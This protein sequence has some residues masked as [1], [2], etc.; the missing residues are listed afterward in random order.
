MTLRILVTNDD[1]INGHGLKVAEGIA[2]TLSDDVWVVAPESEQSGASHSLTLVAPLR[3]R[4]LDDRHFSLTGTPTDC[5][6]MAT[7]HLLK[8]KGPDL[9]ISGVNRGVNVADDVTYS[10]T[11]AGAMEG[12]TLGIPSVALSQGYPFEDKHHMHWACAETHGPTLL[13]KLLDI[14]WSDGVLININFPD[15]PPEGVTGVEIAA[16]GKRDLQEV[17]VDQRTDLRDY[18]YYWIGYKR[19][20]HSSAPGNDL[21]ALMDKK[22]AVTPLQLDLTE[23]NALAALKRAFAK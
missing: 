7:A 6:M 18:P 3:L 4:R 23:R 17:I 16:Q 11:V 9:V 14:G 19:E 10:G 1:G 12:C 8:E 20:P 21:H 22:I 15:C 13:K 5:V 2:R